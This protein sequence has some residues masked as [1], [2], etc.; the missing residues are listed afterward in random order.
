[1][2]ASASV[3]IIIRCVRYLRAGS[4]TKFPIVAGIL[5][6]ST[7]Y[8]ANDLRRQTVDILKTA[9]PSDFNAWCRRNETRLLPHF[10]GETAAMLTL[11]LQTGIRVLL[12]GVYYAAAKRPLADVLEDLH[13]LEVDNATRQDICTKFITGR[14]KLRRT[15]IKT[16][17]SFFEPT[18]ARPGCQNANDTTALQRYAGTALVRTADSEPY[19]DW[20]MSNPALVGTFIGLCPSCCGN[21]ENHIASARLKIW[22]QLPDLF[23]LPSWSVLRA[24]DE[25]DE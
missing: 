25:I 5:R 12:P 14:E 15:E 22:E 7:K 4:R 24:Q 10:V 21:I 1:M 8:V 11:C 2:E 17:L 6:L 3:D 23:G 16:I 19:Q 20:C 13:S 18:F 9:F